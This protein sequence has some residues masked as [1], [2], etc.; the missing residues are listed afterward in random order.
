M[1]TRRRKRD[2]SK[3][4]QCR[5]TAYP[6]PHRCGGGKCS[7]EDWAETY[8]IYSGSGCEACNCYRGQSESCDVGSGAESVEHCEAYM[9]VIRSG[10]NPVPDLQEE[11]DVVF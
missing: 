7:G 2:R 11:F 1:A 5:C 9:E 10:R 8:R 6:F 3:E 4:V